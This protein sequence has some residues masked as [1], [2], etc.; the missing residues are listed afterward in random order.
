MKN[1]EKNY[2]TA[3]EIY[4]SYNVD[5]DAALEAMDNIPISVHCWQIDDLS[6]FEN[7]GGPM[8]GGI[9]AT[10]NARGKP[11][12]PDEY[13]SQLSEALSLIPGRKKVATHAIYLDSKGGSVDRDAIEPNHFSHWVEFAREHGV[14][15]DFNPTYFSHPKSENGFTLSSADEGI[16]SFWVE[17]GRRCRRVGEYFGRETG[18]T[19]YTNHWIPD[20]YKD[21]NVDSLS[22]RTRLIQSLNEIFETPIDPKYNVDSLESKLFGVGL[23]SYTTGSH[24]FYTCYCCLKKKAII[25]LDAG[26]YHPTESIAAKLS[27]Y[28]AFGQ[29]IM[30]HVSRPVRWDSDHVVTLDEETRHIM[31]EIVRC[32][33][34]D[35]VHIGL[36]YFDGSIN[37]VAA[38]AIG[39][40]SAK[41]ALLLALLEPTAMLRECEYSGNYTKRLALLEEIK[42]LPFGFVWDRYC[43]INQCAGDEWLERL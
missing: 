29:E 26:H 15:L 27:A 21:T 23:E 19:C 31:E 33:A 25:C 39:A 4:A 8:T 40:R 5:T 38:T 30:L 11:G 3:K 12:S 28:L 24:D 2:E 41:K 9:M 37:R 22:P 6:G 42:T 7:P 36:D 20:G 32:E 13:F 16:R 18:E 1:T 35:R 34:T 43:E 17:H 10:G 14:G